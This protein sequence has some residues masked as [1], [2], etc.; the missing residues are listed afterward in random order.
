MKKKLSVIYHFPAVQ[1]GQF[2]KLLFGSLPCAALDTVQV[3]QRHLKAGSNQRRDGGNVA[4]RQYQHL[5]GISID[6][7]KHLVL[8]AVVVGV[9][10]FFHSLELR[11]ES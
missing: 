9:D 8:V 2:I 10:V 1:L 5:D 7:V 6:G 11:V 4:G 3:G